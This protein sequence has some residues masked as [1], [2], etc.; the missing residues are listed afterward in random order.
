MIRDLE[1]GTGKYD[2]HKSLANRGSRKTNRISGSAGNSS[3]KLS[4]VF[5]GFLVRKYFNFRTTI[6]VE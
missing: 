6:L 2:Y 5:I 4:V 3:N 1:E